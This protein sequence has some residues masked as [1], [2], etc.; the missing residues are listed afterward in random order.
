[1]SSAASGAL[2]QATSDLAPY[3]L[4]TAACLGTLVVL[5]GFGKAGAGT[6]DPQPQ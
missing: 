2:A 4:L 6:V 1:V 5:R 3:L